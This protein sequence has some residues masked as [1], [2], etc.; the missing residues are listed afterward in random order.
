MNG[1]DARGRGLPKALIAAAGALVL[2]LACGLLYGAAWLLI[3]ADGQ[4]DEPK[5]VERLARISAVAVPPAPAGA[6]PVPG[7]SGAECTDDS[8]PEVWLSAATYYTY[9]GGP[10][11]V[12]DHY[13]D[14]AA[15]A[16]W[17]AAGPRPKVTPGFLLK[18][19]CFRKEVDGKPTLLVVAYSARN[20]YSVSVNAVLDGSRPD[21]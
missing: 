8:G 17:K 18:D 5:G 20:E 7:A 1:T 10:R 9:D 21:C 3:G 6:N 19:M 12:I 4:C 13:W 15:A 11:A 14:A 2:A 16:G